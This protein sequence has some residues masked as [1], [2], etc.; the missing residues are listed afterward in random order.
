MT[1]SIFMT[2]LFCALLASAV[3]LAETPTVFVSIGPQA[4][5]AKRIAGDL[6]DVHVLVGPGQNH[7]TFDPAPK[8]LAELADARAYFTIGLPFEQRL[9]EKL[10]AA[11]PNL[12]IVDTRE[13]I[14]LRAMEADADEP[15]DHDH[16]AMDPHVWLNP[17]NAKVIATH[18]AEG[19]KHIDPAHAADYER[20]LA[21]LL[22]DLDALNARLA[23]ILASCKGKAFYVY[24]PAFGYFADAYGLKQVP[25]EIE[26]KEPTARQL[27][28]LIARAKADGVR[29]IFVQQQFPKKSAEAIACEIHGVAIA[30]DP[31]AEDYLANL[32][33]I[34]KKL[35]AGLR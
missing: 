33:D 2:G 27:A 23:N 15:H 13:G 17:L 26:G 16:G 12:A 22:G 9:V 30:I 21:S 5:L 25:V 6:V 19:L 14:V 4:Y 24:H 18:I 1:R 10:R 32:E 3:A 7:H 28:S 34:A 8:Q 29:A 35:S 20:N 31:L 11:N